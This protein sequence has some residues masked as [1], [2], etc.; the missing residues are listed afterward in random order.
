[1]PLGDPPQRS[2]AAFG[3]GGGRVFAARPAS[4]SKRLCSSPAERASAADLWV[5]RAASP[6]QWMHSLSDTRDTQRARSPA[7]C[8]PCPTA[9]A[10][11]AAATQAPRRMQAAAVAVAVAVTPPP[12]SGGRKGSQ[13]AGKGST[14]RGAAARTKRATVPPTPEEVASLFATLKPDSR[15]GC[16]TQQAVGVPLATGGDPRRGGH[17]T[18][19]RLDDGNRLP[20][21]Q[22]AAPTT[23]G[24][25]HPLA[26]RPVTLTCHGPTRLRLVGRRQATPPHN[27]LLLPQPPARCIHCLA[28]SVMDASLQLGLSLLDEQF[29]LMFDYAHEECSGGHHS[30]GSGASR[31][32]N[33]S[34]FQAV[35]ATLY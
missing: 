8:H 33:L 35:L 2:D 20:S 29:D 26:G 19:G 34:Q 22:P 18:A 17:D 1:M 27:I 10:A 16:I 3:F 32:L 25:K 15:S 9:A 14:K 11:A 28:M 31:R 24:Q 13:G 4:R 21:Q 30:G 6:Q 12:Q 5:Q 23:A 7:A